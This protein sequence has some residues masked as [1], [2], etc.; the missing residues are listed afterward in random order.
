MAT[1]LCGDCGG[2]EVRMKV[3]P[4]CYDSLST[5]EHKY[6]DLVWL[7]E[8]IE[9]AYC[10]GDD[11]PYIDEIQKILREHYKN[12]SSILRIGSDEPLFMGIDP[13]KD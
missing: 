5:I 8:K 2:V 9:G 3:C 7:L 13:A 10:A 12:N 6:K 1:E 4:R 11:V